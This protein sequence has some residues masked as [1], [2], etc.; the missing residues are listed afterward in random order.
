MKSK[1][2]YKSKSNQNLPKFRKTKNLSLKYSNVALFERRELEL[3]KTKQSSPIINKK[4]NIINTQYTSFDNKHRKSLLSKNNYYNF[5]STPSLF[6]SRNKTNIKLDLSPSYTNQKRK[7]PKI[8]L[9]EDLLFQNNIIIK[10]PEKKSNQNDAIKTNLENFYNNNRNSH[11]GNIDFLLTIQ[12]DIKEFRK[13]NVD[14]NTIHKKIESLNKKDRSRRGI[15]KKI[16]KF[17]Y[18]EFLCFLKKERLKIYTEENK[19]NIEFM[20]EK[21]S[22]LTKAMKLFNDKFMN[23][24]TDY[25]RYLDSKKNQGKTENILLLKEKMTLKR[26]IIQIKADIEKIEQKKE[27]ILRWIY[28]QIQ[29]KERRLVLPNYYKKIIESNKFQ[30]LEMESKFDDNFQQ[31]ILKRGKEEKRT[32]NLKKGLARNETLNKKDDIFS[33]FEKKLPMHKY[34]NFA[35]SEKAVFTLSNK[36]FNLVTPPKKINKIKR[37]IGDENNKDNPEEL[38][39]KEEFDKIVFWKFRPIYITVDE[40]MENLNSIYLKNMKMLEYYNQLR[41]KIYC[42]KQELSKAKNL[43]DNYDDN[44]DVQL[45]EKTLQLEKLRNKHILMIKTHDKINQEKQINKK[46][47]DKSVSLSKTDIDKIY[48]KLNDMFD[49]CKL[50][51]NQQL[52]ELIYYYIKSENTKEGEMIYLIEYIESTLDFL[53]GKISIY[54]RNEEMNEKIHDIEIKIDKAHKLEK[55]NKQSL[56]DKKKHLNLI[57]KVLKKSRQQYIIPTRPIDLVNYNF[58]ELGKRKKKEIRIKEEF[59]TLEDFMANPKIIH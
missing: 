59:P 13:R 23:R 46:K 7:I 40:F 15:I 50:V 56:E 34:N 18:N 55:P 4:N 16:N 24:L 58:R 6:S 51:N 36:N 19:N 37:Y 9:S 26:E 41:F 11:N 49:N 53:T 28:L 25:L 32:N 52:T 1:T 43:R 27:G 3:L 12:K 57:K 39:T 29:V 20:E 54:K 10:S 48:D 5:N 35:Q 30:I 33:S 22:S 44:I 45:S 31:A 14:N 38:I 47:N 8:N 42:I 2:F 17:K 21:I